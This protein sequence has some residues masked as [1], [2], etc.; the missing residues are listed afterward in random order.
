MKSGL[1]RREPTGLATGHLSKGR[2]LRGVWGSPP[3]PRAAALT[4]PLGLEKAPS[5]CRYRS[6]R[7]SGS[8]S[9]PGGPRATSRG[10]GGE[11][12]PCVPGEIRMAQFRREKFGCRK[13]LYKSFRNGGNSYVLCPGVWKHSM[14]KGAMRGKRSKILAEKTLKMEKYLVRLASTDFVRT[15]FGP[16]PPPVWGECHVAQSAVAVRAVARAPAHL[17][18]PVAAHGRRHI[19]ACPRKALLGA[20]HI[21][22]PANP[23]PPSKVGGGGCPPPQ[24][25]AW[26]GRRRGRGRS[27]PP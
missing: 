3:A 13:I 11:G 2:R 24:A 19:V 27:P 10:G 4:P 7:P 15:E 5:T 1:Q 26:P 9:G 16:A 20:N 21:G 12:C 22:N 8:G 23:L 18:D 6:R 17:L 14:G 25:A